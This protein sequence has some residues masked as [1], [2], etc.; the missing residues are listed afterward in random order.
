VRALKGGICPL[1]KK[2]KP[3]YDLVSVVNILFL[4]EVN[5]S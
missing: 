2:L 3:N 5:A 4:G 1:D